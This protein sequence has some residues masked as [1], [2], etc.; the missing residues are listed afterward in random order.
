MSL[1]NF[2]KKTGDSNK[3]SSLTPEQKD[4]VEKNRQKALAKLAA[5]KRKSPS[6]SSSS[7]SDG[8]NLNSKRQLRQ[9]PICCF[10]KKKVIGLSAS[11]LCLFLCFQKCVQP[12]LQGLAIYFRLPKI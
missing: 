7:S 3:S 6:S 11:T 10:L 5:K 9:Q 8:S 2:F 4:L 12:V 1:L